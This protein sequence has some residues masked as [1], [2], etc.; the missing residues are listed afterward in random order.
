MVNLKKRKNRAREVALQ[1]KERQKILK[2]YSK[3]YHGKQQYINH[4]KKH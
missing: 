3:K 4:N 2:R 1:F